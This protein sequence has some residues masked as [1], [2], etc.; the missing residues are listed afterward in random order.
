MSEETDITIEC[1][2]L[3]KVFGEGSESKLASQALPIG[4]ECDKFCKELKSSGGIVAS[5]DIN[6]QIKRGEFLF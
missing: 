4:D 3:W 1:K 5:G 6:L 2:K